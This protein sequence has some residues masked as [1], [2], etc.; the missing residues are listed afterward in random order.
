MQAIQVRDWAAGPKLT[1]IPRPSI[2]SNNSTVQVR[3]QA[4]GLHRLVRAQAAGTHP[5]P[6]SALL[7]MIPGVDGVG[8]D[9]STGKRV[10]FHT[11]AAP[12]GTG[13]FAEYI[14]VPRGSVCEVPDGLD[15]ARVAGLMNPMMSS[16]MALRT[17]V[18]L[19]DGWT[20]LILGATSASGK[21][22][23]G[24][25]R[26]MGA[27]KVYG[28]ARDEGRLAELDLDARVVL[29]DSV[30]DTHF[31]GAGEADVVLDY[32]YGPWPKVYL[33]KSRAHSPLTWLSIGNLAGAEA[34]IPGPKLRG[35]D[36]TIR[37]SGL[38]SWSPE[39]MD[40]VEMAGMMD[41]LMKIAGVGS[42]V[43]VWN[44]GEAEEVWRAQLRER[45]VFTF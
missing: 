9:I 25:A 39:R 30:E 37:G 29:K 35:R 33:A 1:T 34:E 38:G 16:W 21:L 14:N 8:V 17:R 23:A 40:A 6:V 31:L 45:V 32:L 36:V 3:V 27:A 10:Y 11:F 5:H 15:S 4:V 12:R 28:A 26:N 42:D 7:P 43:K 13:S 20:C 18:E 19:R 44:I 24:I 22:A 41:V 2:P